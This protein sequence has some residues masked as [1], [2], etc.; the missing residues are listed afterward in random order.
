MIITRDS[1][2]NQEYSFWD[3]KKDQL[4]VINGE[5]DSN[6]V[7]SLLLSVRPEIF[8]KIFN[9]HLGPGD[10]W[11]TSKK[12]DLISEDD[13]EGLTELLSKLQENDQEKEKTISN[14]DFQ[15]IHEDG[16]KY[17]Y[18]NGKLHREDGPAIEY[19]D[20]SKFWYNNDKLHRDDGPAVEHSNGDKFWYKYG[21]LHRDNGPAAE[22]SD[23]SQYWYKNGKLHFS[24]LQKN[25]YKSPP[26][27]EFSSECPK[28]G[29]AEQ[30][31]AEW[32]P[33]GLN[34]GDPEYMN[35]ECRNCGFRRHEQTFEE[36]NRGRNDK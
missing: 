28:C 6:D 22:H 14:S 8:D 21:K 15:K 35:R 17:W 18:H 13:D 32:V 19:P 10:F 30:W 29:N 20:G 7:G 1:S 12:F 9:I 31:T 36:T 24:K 26:R 34:P 16:T 3:T 11:E 4:K 25:D 2:R 27:P 33:Y 5:W 23:G